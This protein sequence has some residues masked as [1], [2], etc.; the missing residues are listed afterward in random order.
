MYWFSIAILTWAKSARAVDVSCVM[1]NQL[2]LIFQLR[3]L[4]GWL[5]SSAARFVAHWTWSTTAPAKPHGSAHR[6]LT[7]G[8]AGEHPRTRE[9]PRYNTD[10]RL[11]YKYHTCI[12][13]NIHI[14]K[15][16]NK[17]ASY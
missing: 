17:N 10:I 5:Q 4:D 1:C 7:L 6:G 9:R 3:V 11:L 15:L 2:L 8:D 16:L 13:H 14:S 12:S